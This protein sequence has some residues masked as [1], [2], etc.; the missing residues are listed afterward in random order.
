MNKDNTYTFLISFDLCIFCVI[1][2]SKRS[3]G[4]HYQYEAC[5]PTYCGSGPNISFPFYVP[6][7]QESYCGYPGFALNCTDDF[8]VLRLPENEYV[9]TDI[10]YQ[11]RSFHIYNAAVLRS[12]DSSCLPTI[13]NTT[14]PQA[15]FDYVNVT[16]LHLFSNCKNLSGELLRYNVGCDSYGDGNNG[17]LALYDIDENLR[18]AMEKCEENIVAPVEG[19][20]DEGNNG[21]VNVS[22]A[23]RRGFVLNWTASDCGTCED[24]GGRCGFNETSFHFKC[25]CPDRP[26]SRSCKPGKLF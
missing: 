7:R 13:R 14:L 6:T 18:N 25:F 15:L 22:K 21:V 8:P 24:S 1:I 16:D 3:S 17:T 20:G 9:V 19:D 26:H 2:L 12:D 11:N 4:A 5:A 23:L 10:F